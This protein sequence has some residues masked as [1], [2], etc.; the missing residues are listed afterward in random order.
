MDCLI[1]LQAHVHRA[2][3][4]EMAGETPPGLFLTPSGLLA[5]AGILGWQLHHPRVLSPPFLRSG[6]FLLM[7][8]LV[9][10]DWGPLYPRMTTS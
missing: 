8:A 6:G 3:P 5:A 2:T 9:I 7:K 4:P 10:L 1:V